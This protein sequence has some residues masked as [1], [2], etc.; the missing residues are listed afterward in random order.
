MENSNELPR[1]EWGSDKNI[2]FAVRDLLAAADLD[3]GVSW[4]VEHGELWIRA[5]CLITEESLG[6][7]ARPCIWRDPYAH[8]V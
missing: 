4:Q 5:G 3:V 1:G 8:R 2:L 7:E 6:F